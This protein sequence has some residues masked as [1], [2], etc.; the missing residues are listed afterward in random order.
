MKAYNVIVL[1]HWQEPKLLMCRRQHPPFQGKLNLVGGKVE[2]NEAP[3]DA[4]YR[5]LW[6]ET[7]ITR[8]D[9]ELHPLM[10]TQYYQDNIELQVFA[11]RLCRPISPAGDENPLLWVSQ[12]ENF[13]DTRF[14]GNG[15]IG[16]FVLEAKKLFQGE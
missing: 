13:F 1:F 15:N 8:Q 2:P 11:G 10:T 4:A 16:H 5:E 3:L 12:K 7:G 6:E 9:M 14:A